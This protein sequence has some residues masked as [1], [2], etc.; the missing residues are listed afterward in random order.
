MRTTIFRMWVLFIPFFIAQLPA[1]ENF[2]WCKLLHYPFK[3]GIHEGNQ[4]LHFKST[5]KHFSQ[6]DPAKKFVETY[7]SEAKPLQSEAELLRVASDAVTISGEYLE[8]GVCTGRTINF[9]AALNPYKKIYGFDSFEGNPED[10]IRGDAILSKGIFAFKNPYMFPP[11]LQN[12]VLSKG[13]FRN[14]LPSFKHSIL[15]DKPIAFLHIDCD[16]YS[17]TTDVFDA[18]GDNIKEG[19]IIVFD[20]LYNYPGYENHEFKAFVEFLN[21]KGLGADF[22]AYNIYHEQVA[23]KITQKKLEPITSTQSVAKK[24]GKTSRK[25]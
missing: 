15:Q 21:K 24:R 17:S 7:L 18:L 16:I 4:I 8:M 14:T 25:R 12:V 22:I 2:D 19:T 9:I 13:W 10:W 5:N 23:V 11:V 6:S 1:Q 3:V 20:E